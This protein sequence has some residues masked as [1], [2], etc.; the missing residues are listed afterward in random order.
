MQGILTPRTHTPKTFTRPSVALSA[1]KHY[2][3]RSA[4]LNGWQVV[5]M[6]TK[7]NSENYV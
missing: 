4:E 1:T 3:V 2:G 5:K 7:K 6:G